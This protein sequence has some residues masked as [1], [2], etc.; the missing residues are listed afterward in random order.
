[1]KEDKKNNGWRIAL[2]VVSF[3]GLSLV[4][5]EYAIQPKTDTYQMCPNI[6]IVGS[7]PEYHVKEITR[8]EEAVE[9]IILTL[10]SVNSY[11]ER[12]LLSVSNSDD[13][14]K[15]YSFQFDGEYTYN[16]LYKDGVAST[17]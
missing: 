14:S 3:I 7:K 16:I 13:G 4:V 9:N 8:Y 2:F 11:T 1:M 6:P 5:I 12:E 10:Q 15:I 17:M